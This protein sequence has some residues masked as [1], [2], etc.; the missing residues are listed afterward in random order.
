MTSNPG[1]RAKWWAWRVALKERWLRATA[2]VVLWNIRRKQQASKRGITAMS[3]AQA[4]RCLLIS[5]DD[6]ERYTPN[7]E[8]V[9]DLGHTVA[10]GKTKLTDREIEQRSR[11]MQEALRKPR[12]ED[13]ADL[14]WME[15]NARRLKQNDKNS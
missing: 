4:E 10:P 6:S 11:Q 13:K 3:R 12:P 8:V 14:N 2:P 1:W 5:F 9:V 7:L 15:L